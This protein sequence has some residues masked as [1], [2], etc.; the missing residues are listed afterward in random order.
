[1]K[2][3]PRSPAMVANRSAVISACFSL[4]MAQGPPMR[5]SGRPPP[6]RTGPT[7]TGR[8]AVI[9]GRGTARCGLTQD[10]SCCPPVLERGPDE[11][12]KERVRVPGPGA[13]LGMEL[14]G[15]EVGVLGQ[16]DDLHQLLLGPQAGH[17]QALL[18]QL[19]Q[20]LVVHL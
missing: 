20:V 17:A 13:Q 19:L 11:P 12:G 5:A 14:A 1:M 15:H 9:C 18:L 2:G 6:M 3:T 7:V 8:M 10:V 4:S 16:L